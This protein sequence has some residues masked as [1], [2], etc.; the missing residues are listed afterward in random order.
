V[1]AYEWQISV[2]GIYDT[3]EYNKFLA[4]KNGK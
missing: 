4:I 3:N 2:G 1:K